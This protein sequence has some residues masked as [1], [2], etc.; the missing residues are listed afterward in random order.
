MWL[1]LACDNNALINHS[2]TIVVQ[3]GVL[4]G[5]SDLLWVT[6]SDARLQDILYVCLFHNCFTC[7]VNPTPL[8]IH[9]S[10]Q[11]PFIQF[12][13]H[14]TETFHNLVL[15]PHSF[16]RRL[17]S[18]A[19]LMHFR[20]THCHRMQCRM[21]MRNSGA[22]QRN[23]CQDFSVICIIVCTLATVTNCCVLRFLTL[24]WEKEMSSLVLE[25]HVCFAA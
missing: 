10:A 13:C 12:P 20:W 19:D 5:P 6:E 14:G 23:A 17:R 3:R 2:S 1:L 4:Q 11:T 21:H 9:L 8:V 7:A 25:L 15:G 24:F 18:S 22:A 16:F